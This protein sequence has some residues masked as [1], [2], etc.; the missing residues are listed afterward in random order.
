MTILLLR[1]LAPFGH[2]IFMRLFIYLICNVLKRRGN[3]SVCILFTYSKM[4]RERGR[5]KGGREISAVIF[6][7]V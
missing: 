3:E 1:S 7:Q 4:S 2:K 6:A 5:D